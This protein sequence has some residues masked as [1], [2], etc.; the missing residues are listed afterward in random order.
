MIT[1]DDVRRIKAILIE[2]CEW[3]GADTERS[4]VNEDGV[5]EWIT[6]SC[7][8]EAIAALIADGFDVYIWPSIHL[9]GFL[10]I[11]IS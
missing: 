8:G 9:Q 3:L 6:C 7:C 2:H 10:E 11:H 5:F 1:L 4:R